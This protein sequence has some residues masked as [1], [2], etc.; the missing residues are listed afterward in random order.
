[1]IPPWSAPTPTFASGPILRKGIAPVSAPPAADASAAFQSFPSLMAWIAPMPAPIAAF[2]RMPPGTKLAAS[3]RP[4]TSSFPAG[5][6][7]KVE[8]AAA[9]D[10]RPPQAA[11]APCFAA[12][13]ART[14][15]PDF[16]NPYPLRTARPSGEFSTAPFT[17]L[18]PL[19]RPV[20]MAPATP[21]LWA[22][23]SPECTFSASQCGPPDASRSAQ[24]AAA[25]A[26]CSA[27]LAPDCTA[28]SPPLLTRASACA[29]RLISPMTESIP[30]L[31]TL[32]TPRAV[33]FTVSTAE[34]PM[35]RSSPPAARPRLLMPSPTPVA[36]SE[37]VCVAPRAVRETASSAPEA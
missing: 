4:V 20:P 2:T 17:K 32:S 30:F 5:D 28:C 37:S 31:T 25:P 29:P 18:R 34:R 27:Q 8:V 6:C 26:L 14:S 15:P 35:L 21:V 13:Q 11:P 19:R 12:F 33:R 9:A 24:R 7:R 23:S 22:H 16:T 3:E 10:L 36:T 1:M